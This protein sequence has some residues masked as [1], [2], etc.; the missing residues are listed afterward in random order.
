MTY[1]SLYARGGFRY[2]AKLWAPRLQKLVDTIGIEGD[3]LDAPAG[4]G[5]WSRLL[6]Q[7]MARRQRRIAGAVACKVTPIDLSVVGCEK[8]G[9]HV[10]DLNVFNPEW[11][12]RF[13][14]L[15]CR[16]ISH[17]HHEVIDATPF[18]HFAKY[19]PCWC[20]IYSTTQTGKNSKSGHHWNHRKAVL[21]RLL[22]QFVSHGQTW[23]SWSDRGY[24]HFVKSWED[25]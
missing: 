5:F 22:S 21:D 19:A 3:V 8:S 1:D 4:D 7:C 13:S 2:S 6:A 23:W 10:W 14:W 11:A 9:G 25:G 18:E 16:G 17:L 15:F 20:V 24:Y 12:N